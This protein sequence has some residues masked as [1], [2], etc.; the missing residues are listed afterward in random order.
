MNSKLIGDILAGG[1][2][3]DRK[4]KMSDSVD[5]L[6]KCKVKIESAKTPAHLQHEVNVHGNRGYGQGR[7]M[8][9]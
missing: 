9:D 1:R 5:A 7:K 3:I 2:V 6:V 8:G 4:K